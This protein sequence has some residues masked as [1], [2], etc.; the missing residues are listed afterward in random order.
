MK[1]ISLF[2]IIV[3]FPVVASTAGMTKQDACSY[4]DGIYQEQLYILWPGK[5]VQVDEFVKK[6]GFLY[7]FINVFPDQETVD[8]YRANANNADTRHSSVKND[9][10]FLAS[11]DCSRSKVKFYSN[12]RSLGGTAYGKLNWLAGRYLSY[13]L[14]SRGRDPCTTWPDML[15][16]M[17][18]MTNLRLD[19]TMRFLRST[20]NICI[21]RSMYKSVEDGKIQFDIEEYH[22]DTE[23][24]FYSRYQYQFTTK[25]LKKIG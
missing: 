21:G 5:I 19:K 2:L 22:R 14:L 4:P 15:I 18:R 13:S 9:G 11:Y 6:D 25:K 16:D 10:S 1:N 7:Y 8:A 3:L 20:P 23:E 12:I 17:D 24:S